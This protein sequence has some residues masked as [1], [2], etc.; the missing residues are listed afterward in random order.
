MIPVGQHF[1]DR[2]KLWQLGAGRV[3]PLVD[4]GY[5][6][7]PYSGF[8]VPSAITRL[9]ADTRQL[10]EAGCVPRPYL[11]I[12]YQP[13]LTLA[14]VPTYYRAAEAAMR[15]WELDSIRE[16]AQLTIICGN[17]PNHPGEGS[18]QPW[19]YASVVSK[20]V[21]LRNLLGYGNRVFAPAIAPWA[22]LNVDHPD[23][24]FP[25][26]S[27]EWKNQQYGLARALVNSG[28]D[29]HALHTYGRPRGTWDRDEPHT[30]ITN[31][32]GALWGFRWYRDA[33]EAI[34]AAG[35]AFPV[36][37]AETNTR[38]DLPSAQS[39]PQGWLQEAVRELE[40][41][42]YA[43]RIEGLVW[44]VGESHGAWLDESLK[45]REGQVAFADDDLNAL[46]QR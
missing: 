12:D 38:T 21:Q 9:K 36:L 26:P 11:R 41:S 19:Q 35:G 3:V 1:L 32:G 33:L 25:G 4:L 22:P 37:V 45:Q 15:S 30:N 24:F 29:G 28:I 34:D 13:G 5:A 14:D 42:P 18:L 7:Q 8:D 10:H 31:D 40:D 6:H 43:S 27:S 44:F 2:G 20:T 17:E 46:L 16:I 23:D 39:Y